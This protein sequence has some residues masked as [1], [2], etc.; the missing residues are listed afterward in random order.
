MIL[1][2]LLRI[3][4]QHITAYYSIGIPAVSKL[5][6]PPQQHKLKYKRAKLCKFRED[7]YLSC[8]LNRL[9]FCHIDLILE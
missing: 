6:I 4:I 8:L 5:K 2:T 3:A 1:K 9:Y 7:V